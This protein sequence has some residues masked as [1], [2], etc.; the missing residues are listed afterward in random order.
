MCEDRG[1]ARMN[2]ITGLTP[3]LYEGRFVTVLHVWA[4]V[5]TD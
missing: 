2:L 3:V 1:C 5:G 4:S